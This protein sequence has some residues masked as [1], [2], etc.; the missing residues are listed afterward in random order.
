[1]LV[2]REAELLLVPAR[3]CSANVV[4]SAK[5]CRSSLLTMFSGHLDTNVDIYEGTGCVAA[6]QWPSSGCL[7]CVASVLA[8]LAA[9]CYLG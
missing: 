7:Q 1:M 6:H 9:L 5:R 2:S 8:D 4:S 3:L